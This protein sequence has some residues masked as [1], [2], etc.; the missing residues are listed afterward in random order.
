[1]IPQGDERQD[2]TCGRASSEVKQIMGVHGQE[3][4]LSC[5]ITRYPIDTRFNI[6]CFY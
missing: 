5:D 4:G 2:P 3:Q 6:S 1:M